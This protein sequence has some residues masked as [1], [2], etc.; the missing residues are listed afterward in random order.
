VA[1]HV[2]IRLV[3]PSTQRASP[4]LQSPVH[5]PLPLHTLWQGASS[6]FVPVASQRKGVSPRHP[7]VPGWHDPVQEVVAPAPLHTNAHVV[8]VSRQIPC[9]SHCWIT[10]LEGLQRLSPAVHAAVHAPVAGSQY[11]R[12]LEGQGA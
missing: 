8:G 3:E 6:W 11:W 2:S 10:G 5:V 4:G 7:L 9:R 12:G 1:S